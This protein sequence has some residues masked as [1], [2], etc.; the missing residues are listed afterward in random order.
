MLSISLSL[1]HNICV[2]P[3]VQTSADTADGSIALV[4]YILNIALI[5]ILFHTKMITSQKQ[6]ALLTGR[7]TV[8]NERPKIKRGGSEVRQ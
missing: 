1:S 5:L 6:E 7:I 8:S 2:S 3:A 4:L